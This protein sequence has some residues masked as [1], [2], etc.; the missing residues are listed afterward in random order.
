[1]PESLFDRF[2]TALVAAL[3]TTL[4]AVS[5]E[6]L[7]QRGQNAR[8]NREADQ[9]IT[10]INFL[11]AWLTLQER[12]SQSQ[13]EAA[14]VAIA[15]ELAAIREEADRTWTAARQAQQSVLR[16]ALTKLL[17]LGVSRIWSVQ[18]LRVVYWIALAWLVAIALPQFLIDVTHPVST[19]ESWA[20]WL[21]WVSGQFVHHLLLSLILVILLRYLIRL[22][23]Q[24]IKKASIG[25]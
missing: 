13:A 8:V 17:M 16:Q 23:D 12:V 20:G 5:A 4:V 22:W 25:H 10:R 14:R 1:M 7:K 21:G 9:S 11:A 3:A 19:I 24:D 2:A 18:L 6:W 15:R